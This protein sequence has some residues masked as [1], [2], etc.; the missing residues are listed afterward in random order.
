MTV[1]ATAE[2]RNPLIDDLLALQNAE[3]VI[4]RMTHEEIMGCMQLGLF[5]TESDQYY[6]SDYA[7]RLEGVAHYAVLPLGVRL[8]E[9]GAELVPLE[10]GIH[11]IRLRIEAEFVDCLAY[12]AS[13]SALYWH[14]DEALVS[15]DGYE[16]ISADSDVG[17]T[18]AAAR[19]DTR[20]LPVIHG[21]AERILT[22]LF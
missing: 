10:Q 7:K 12:E 9:A 19:S 15:R 1:R 22:A 20:A 18:I 4:C 16:E 21:I 5:D 8:C 11:G 13:V 2:G 14:G 17:A 6:E 3:R